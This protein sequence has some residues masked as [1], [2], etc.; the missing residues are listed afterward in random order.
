MPK[1]INLG[2]RHFL[3]IETGITDFSYNLYIDCSY[4]KETLG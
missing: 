4:L 3:L 2:K 1:K